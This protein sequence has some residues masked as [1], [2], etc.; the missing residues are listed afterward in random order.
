MVVLTVS[1]DLQQ[2]EDLKFQFFS[3][4]ACPQPPLEDPPKIIVSLTLAWS[5]IYFGIM[6]L[7]FQ[8]L[9]S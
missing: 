9:S 7:Y 1:M 8:C 6:Y 4:G 2:I 5:I 3:R